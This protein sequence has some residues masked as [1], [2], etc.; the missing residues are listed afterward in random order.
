V[1]AAAL[2]MAAQAASPAAQGSPV[3]D[4][5]AVTARKL[6]RLRIGTHKNRKTGVVTCRYKSRSGDPELDAGVCA[7]LLDCEPKVRTRADIQACMGPAIKA[8]LPKAEWEK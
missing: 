5:V 3:I 8:L 4:D 1:I 7:A 6:G 2:L